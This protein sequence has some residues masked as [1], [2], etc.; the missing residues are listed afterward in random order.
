MCEGWLASWEMG[1]ATYKDSISDPIL[2]SIK[3]CHDT[4]SVA[5][6]KYVE[7]SLRNDL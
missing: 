1:M 6:N 7:A 4:S 2:S 3:S 5:Q